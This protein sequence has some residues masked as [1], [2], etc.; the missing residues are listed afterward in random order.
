MG[1][2]TII[3]DDGEGRYT[4]EV[5]HDT[6][7]ADR[8]LEILNTALAKVESNI[9]DNEQIIT[10]TESDQ[11]SHENDLEI[12]ES[13]LKTAQQNLETAEDAMNSDP[14]YQSALQDLKDAQ[15]VLSAAQAEDPVDPQ[16]IS[17]AQAA[18]ETAK[19]AL[20]NV[21]TKV[22]Y[23]NA[24]DAVDEYQQ[25]VDDLNS[26]LNTLSETLRALQ[27]L[28][29]ELTLR[30]VALEKRRD[31]VQTARDVDYQT[32][33]WCADYS[34]G[35][36][37]NVGTIEPGT[38]KKN[39]INIQPGYGNESAWDQARD[40]IMTPFLTM[41]V[42]DAMRNFAALPA[43]QKWRPN[44]RY[45][46]ISNIDDDAGTC[47]VTLDAIASTIHDLNINQVSVLHN[48]PIE[49]MSCNA[50]AFENG[51]SVIV[52]FDN[53]LQGS[54]RVIGFKEQP[55]PCESRYIKVETA[56]AVLIYD[57]VGRRIPDDLPSSPP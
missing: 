6:T 17:N 48:V 51:D 22:A 26:Y 50:A 3:S 18:L 31:R 5:K 45:G 8:H 13:D 37:G 53:F 49:Y 23:E 29:K 15:N 32:Q 16:K 35:L 33:A 24:S 7:A 12:A 54:P 43:I 1:K 20:D 52:E 10:N 39:G 4:I 34:E 41:H 46:A 27:L 19:T 36:T 30:K 9:G 40:G 28:D 42:A 38:Q 44:Y 47:T 11:A 21:A 25:I 57:I 14:A 56:N 55:R 2:A